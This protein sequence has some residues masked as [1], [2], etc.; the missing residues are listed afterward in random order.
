M[1]AATAGRGAPQGA[2]EGSGLEEAGPES[3]EFSR[4]QA[5]NGESLENGLGDNGGD[6]PFDRGLVTLEELRELLWVTRVPLDRLFHAQGIVRRDVGG[7]HAAE[8]LQQQ[9][10]EAGPITSA[11]A[12][13]HDTSGLSPSNGTDGGGSSLGPAAEGVS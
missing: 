8:M 1:T 7:Q 10:Q 12:G 6:C 2:G 11:A 3:F 4:L 9:S 5:S 13:D